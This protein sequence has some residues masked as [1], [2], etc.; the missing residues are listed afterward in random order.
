M[1]K[2]DKTLTTRAAYWASLGSS[3]GG[4]VRSSTEIEQM[5]MQQLGTLYNRDND[6]ELANCLN[7]IR[8][9]GKDKNG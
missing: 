5:N 4:H 1:A 2:N 9:W 6:H 3:K 7:K 8:D